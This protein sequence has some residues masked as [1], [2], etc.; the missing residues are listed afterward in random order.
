MNSL[1]T[2]VESAYR[3]R[4]AAVVETWV[5][6]YEAGIYG[7]PLATYDPVADPSMFLKGDTA[8]SSDGERPSYRCG[9]T[10]DVSGAA[11]P[12]RWPLHGG[13]VI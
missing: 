4:T 12:D 2:A 6:L 11:R 1:A 13:R 8:G 7:T 5:T 9:H 3:P 10:A